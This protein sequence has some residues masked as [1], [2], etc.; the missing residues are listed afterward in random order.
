[1]SHSGLEEL[2]AV[3]GVE[4]GVLGPPVSKDE[5]DTEVVVKKD[6]SGSI[7]A[8]QDVRVQRQPKP[9][10]KVD[11]AKM[12]ELRFS[13][14]NDRKVKAKLVA[15]TQKVITELA[16]ETKYLK[17]EAEWYCSAD[18][19]CMNWCHNWINDMGCKTGRLC[20]FL[21]T[22]PDEYSFM[23]NRWEPADGLSKVMRVEILRVCHMVASQ[24][25]SEEAKRVP[26]ER[27]PARGTGAVAKQKGVKQAGKQK[28]ATK[29]EAKPV[30]VK[31]HFLGV[32]VAD[33]G[34][35][36][37]LGVQAVAKANSPREV[38]VGQLELARKFFTKGEIFPMLDC[39]SVSLSWASVIC[40][41]L[42]NVD[43]EID[44]SIA[45]KFS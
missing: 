32:G 41:Q 11:L 40:G 34:K 26:D 14:S 23:I 3:G 37:N 16:V 19:I 24:R 36:L 39:C 29:Q 10:D 35:L 27:A 5:P 18:F 28:A 45:V 25:K 15:R 22:S 12:R 9:V 30:A 4:V 44:V 20:K 31:L 38:M 1:M 17:V 42:R 43:E 8:S 7:F 33:L 21:H 13:N 6:A 2:G